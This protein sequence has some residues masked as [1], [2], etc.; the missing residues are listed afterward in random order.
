M[1]L[2][3]LSARGTLRRLEEG[4]HTKQLKHNSNGRSLKDKEHT[5]FT[6]NA[7]GAIGIQEQK[8]QISAV[9]RFLSCVVLS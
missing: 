9:S 1:V 5:K 3:I 4:H 7:K 8:R 2:F 6:F